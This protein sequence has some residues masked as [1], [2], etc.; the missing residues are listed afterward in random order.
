[1][2]IH[3][4]PVDVLLKIFDFC[5]MDSNNYGTSS[6]PGSEWHILVHV[7][8]RWRHTVF[9]SPR[10]L[11][12]TLFCTY[13]TP[14]RKNLSC[15][16]PLPIIMDY[17]FWNRRRPVPN[18]EDDVIAALEHPDRVRGIKLAVTS[19]LLEV[20]AS[21]MQEPFLAL[22]TLWLASNDRNAPVLPD[23]FLS[24][25]APNLQ[26]IYLAG[27]SFPALPTLLLSASEL[28]DLQLEDIP[29]GGYISPE[30]MV[31]SL[32]ALTRLESL[33]IWFKSPTSPL[34]LICSP[35]STQNVLPSLVTFNFCGSSE[36]LEHLLARIDT[37]RLRSFTTT[38][39]NQLD[40]QVPQL[41]QFIRRTDNLELARSRHEQVRFRISNAYIELN[42]EEKGHR[43][44][45]L[46]FCISC[47]LL[48]WQISHL[49]Q[50]LGQSPAMVS[51]VDH[52]SIGGVDPQLD[53][54]WKDDIDDTDWLEL[55]RPFTAVKM[56]RGSRQLAGHIAR[57]LD[58]ISGE[59]VTEVLPALDSLLLEDQSGRSVERF[60]A[61]RQLSGHP[62]IF[63]R[64]TQIQSNGRGLSKAYHL[65]SVVSSP[66]PCSTVF[67]Y[68]DSVI[69]F[70]TA[71]P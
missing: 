31:T 8:Q 53:P 55:L 7:C 12:L 22:T 45:R 38:Y 13:G 42:F 19:S 21:V 66:L 30:A 9:A 60:I 54:G 23:V 71:S 6:R 11:D 18:Y 10:R 64:I 3:I 47:K 69:P 1:M 63:T 67:V 70:I 32:A 5:Q 41:S 4:L 28:V 40:F 61:V 48:D 24:G 58:G 44:S 16:P 62:V 14:V 56:L 52:L 2:T 49:A 33:C 15:W 29:R 57:A 43:R 51:N 39:F 37:P 68:Y 17:T 20:V 27:I 65:R 59:M 25:S 34:E 50:I 46:T 26:Q 35:L 36:Y